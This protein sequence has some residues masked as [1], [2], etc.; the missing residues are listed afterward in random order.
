MDVLL[1]VPIALLVL[2]GMGV[3]GNRAGARAARVSE[4]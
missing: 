3:A 2:V 4:E 1:I